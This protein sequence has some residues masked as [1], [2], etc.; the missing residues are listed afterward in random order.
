MGL[1]FLLV[2]KHNLCSLRDTFSFNKNIRD[3]SLNSDGF[4][5]PLFDRFV[6][7]NISVHLLG[8]A[9]ANSRFRSASILLG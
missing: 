7:C 4:R 6:A 1:L 3:F 9:L 2:F 8:L 5:K